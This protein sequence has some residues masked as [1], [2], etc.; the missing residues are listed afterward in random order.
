[1]M[2]R[3]VRRRGL[4]GSGRD[5]IEWY[6]L[7]QVISGG[8]WEKESCDGEVEA[9]KD[10]IYRKFGGGNRLTTISAV[11]WEGF[12]SLFFLEVSS[13]KYPWSRFGEAFC[14]KSNHCSET[15][16]SSIII[17]D[18]ILTEFLK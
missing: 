8:N 6:E 10:G 3:R 18:M 13:P 12:L 5:A 14:N 7:M 1:M 2:E 16:P 15:H 17:Q 9:V 4:I 11:L